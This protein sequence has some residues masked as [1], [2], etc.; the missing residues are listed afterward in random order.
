MESKKILY[1]IIIPCYNGQ[2]FL[3]KSLHSIVNQNIINKKLAHLYEV[4]I[5]ND[6]STDKSLKIAKKLAND[7]NKQVRDQFIRVIN[8][9]NGQYG[10]VINRGIKEAQGLYLKI[11]D[12][13]DTLNSNNFIKLLYITASLSKQV[14]VI[15]TDYT[16]EKVG[17]NKNYLK[18]FRNVI[19]PNKIIDTNLIALPRD[20]IT[21][22]SIIYRRKFLLDLH[23]KQTEKIYYTD[24][25]YAILPLLKVKAFY[26]IKLPLYR[27]YIG[28]NE[29]SINM[30][31]MVKNRDHQL[32]VLIKIWKNVDLEKLYSKKMILYATIALRRLAQWQVLLIVNS[33][34]IKNKRKFIMD[35]FAFLRTLQP[36]YHKLIMRG[37]FF[38]VFKL[39][40]GYGASKIL[41]YGEKMYS[42]FK[43]NI[44]SDW[45]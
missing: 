5:I 25:E 28:R 23:Y 7:W 31:N 11:L 22:H 32:K 16:F 19:E 41:K 29:Q 27:Y 34:N 18:S 37:A 6:G 45:G 26:Y 40:R 4:I 44:L 38:A 17:I 20:I 42:K 15:I 10:S 2:N 21:M 3:E 1:S 33:N 35:F 30:N 43:T 14:D 36:K 8:K 9:K 12:V 39:T 13:D 24:S